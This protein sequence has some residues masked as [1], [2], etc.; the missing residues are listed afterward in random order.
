MIRIW[1][2]TIMCTFCYQTQ[3]CSSALCIRV[4]QRISIYSAVANYTRSQF[5]T[6]GLESQ[7]IV[8]GWGLLKK[9]KADKEEIKFDV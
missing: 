8:G 3:R 9:M 5:L 2:M 7:S 1:P 4:N 6:D